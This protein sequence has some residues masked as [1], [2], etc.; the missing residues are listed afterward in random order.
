MESLRAYAM[1]RE[2]ESSY[3]KVIQLPRT[4]RS[5]PPASLTGP[6]LQKFGE[7]YGSCSKMRELY[8]MLERV[9]PTDA[10]VFIVGESGTG[11]ELVA[12]TVHSMSAR[13]AEPFLAINCGAIPANLIEAELF[14]HEKGSFTGANRQHKGYFERVGRGTLLLDEITEMST[15]MQVK[16]LRVLETGRFT[17][18]GGDGEIPAEARIIAAT[19][20]EPNAAMAEGKLRPDLLYRL[21]VF[22]VQVPPL[23]DRGGDV[24]GLAEHFLR[25]LNEEHDAAKRLSAASRQ[26][27]QAHSWPGNVREL[28]NVLQRA[29][30]MSDDDIEVE[31]LLQPVRAEGVRHMDGM[32][33]IAV[34]TP[35]AQA[36]REMIFATLQYCQGNKRR[37]AQ[38]LGLSLKTLYNRLAAY[39]AMRPAQDGER[40]SASAVNG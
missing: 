15:E 2:E 9:A 26:G 16:L 30:I 4:N 17:R 3:T 21:S 22:P 12:R 8:T 14:G 10:T 13:K 39:Q 25:E 37:A 1:D 32:L 7:L 18:V 5:N 6:A 28:K 31:G 36:E 11:K 23:R 29:F 34:G 35:L 27:L 40:A 38:I 24:V 19:N 33:A 20:R